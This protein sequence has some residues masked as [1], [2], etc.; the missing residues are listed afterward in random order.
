MSA[1]GVLDIVRT[2]I[3]GRRGPKEEADLP[4]KN[5]SSAAFKNLDSASI[6]VIGSNFL[7]PANR[8]EASSAYRIARRIADR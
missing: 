6:V 3:L 8:Y 2:P 5:N 1:S 7:Y 4:W